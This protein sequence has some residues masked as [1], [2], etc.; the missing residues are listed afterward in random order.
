MAGSSIDSSVPALTRLVR[1][2]AL[3]AAQGASIGFA[4][5][6]LW[7]WSRIGDF[8]GTNKIASSDRKVI[9]ACLIAPAIAWAALGLAVAILKPKRH[10]HLSSLER[11]AQRCS[12]LIA[13]GFM[14]V[15]LHPTLWKNRTLMFLISTGVATLVTWWSIRVTQKGLRSGHAPRESSPQP[16]S[17]QW[18][19]IVSF[20]GSLVPDRLRTLAPMFVIFAL[21]IFIVVRGVWID[22]AAVPRVTPA[23]TGAT[24]LRQAFVILGHGGWLGIPFA[25]LQAFR[26]PGHAHLVLWA[27]GV[28]LAAFPLYLWAKHYLGTTLA[29]FVSLVYLST[30]VLRILGQTEL[31]PLGLAAGLFFWAAAE[32]ERDRLERAIVLSFLTVGVHE[33][34]ALWFACF[35]IYLT[36]SGRSVGRGRWLALGSLG[37]FA[38]I[39]FALLP[40]LGQDAYGHGFRGMWGAH[41]VGLIETLKVA[42]SNPAYV[43]VRWLELQGLQFWLALFVPFAFIPVCGKRWVLWAVPGLIFGLIGPGHSPKLPLTAGVLSHFVVLGFVASVTTLGRLR[44]TVQ[45]R[46]QAHAAVI[47]WVFALI[48]SVY[49]LGGLWLPAP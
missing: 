22:P 27:A 6:T 17:S 8:V 10:Q 7:M 2:S 24:S 31:I 38:L 40:S 36:F 29:L 35:G 19:K 4:I 43:L 25:F 28:S 49:Q 26:P 12:W 14:P 9:L 42:V 39:A 1:A 11:L 48:P 33:Q 21:V 3:L 15:L 13:I 34:A 23:P 32:W 30:P 44:A 18:Q 20:A 46:P 16:E 45:T 47:A 5:N 37:Y 41:A